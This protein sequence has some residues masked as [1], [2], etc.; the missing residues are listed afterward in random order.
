[1]TELKK[2]FLAVLTES[3]KNKR[4]YWWLT[5][6]ILTIVP[7]GLAPNWL[8]F[9]RI[10]LVAA[11]YYLWQVQEAVTLL[12]LLILGVAA[13]TDWIDGSMART[14]NKVTALGTVLDPIADDILGAW[15]IIL[16]ISSGMLHF[17]TGVGLIIFEA[18]LT[19]GAGLWLLG[20]WLKCEK[21]N[22]KNAARQI[23]AV[24]LENLKVNII[25]RLR[26]GMMLT[27]L[28]LLI[29]ASSRD[30]AILFAL[31]SHVYLPLILIGIAFLVLGFVDN[32]GRL[33]NVGKFITGAAI[34]ITTLYLIE[35]FMLQIGQ[36]LLYLSLAA[37]IL[38]IAGYLKNIS[39][40]QK[41]A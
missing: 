12:Q 35:P 23:S 41:A 11:S 21:N 4:D 6:W 3:E 5:Q 39:D 7:L 13:L 22:F 8:T 28:C 26:F 24:V 15:I 10:A 40:A 17:W 31:F 18:L 36:W 20:E 27:G 34:I 33:I 25:S 29:L 38:E 32:K 1:M 2:T 19:V 16:L 9:L 14:R 37:F 30:R